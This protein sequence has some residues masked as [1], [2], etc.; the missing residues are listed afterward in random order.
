MK[1][2]LF[3]IVAVAI[4]FGQNSIPIPLPPLKI[5]AHWFHTKPVK[6]VDA[7]QYMVDH[8]DAVFS[9]MHDQDHRWCEIGPNSADQYP[10][11]KRCDGAI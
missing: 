1:S 5:E 3:V 11:V 7:T 10:E 8:A 4:C 9:I 2:L 6:P